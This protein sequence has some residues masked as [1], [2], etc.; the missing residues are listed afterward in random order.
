MGAVRRAVSAI[1]RD[2]KEA[3]GLLVLALV[4]VAAVRALSPWV[5][6]LLAV[7][8]V[9]L[10]YVPWGR[11]VRWAAWLAVSSWSVV[12][13]LASL[14]GWWWPADGLAGALLI[15]AGVLMLV[16]AW[17]TRIPAPPVAQMAIG[18]RPAVVGR[19]GDGG[20][21]EIASSSTDPAVDRS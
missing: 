14:R 5:S 12:C 4:G 1:A 3:L 21:A 13:G 2:R 8:G 9:M 17:W 7:F 10:F 18:P 15:V 20:P 16:L 6:G 11:W 19:R